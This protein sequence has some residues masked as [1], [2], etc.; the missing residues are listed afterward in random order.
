VVR[1]I[2]DLAWNALLGFL[3]LYWLMLEIMARVNPPRDIWGETDYIGKSA[4]IWHVVSTPREELPEMVVRTY[5][6]AGKL[7]L[8][9]MVL[10]VVTAILS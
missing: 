1:A 5:L 3:L 7:I 9:L 2:D 6:L 8:A 4:G 10:S